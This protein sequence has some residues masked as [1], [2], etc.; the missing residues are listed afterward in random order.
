MTQAWRHMA[1]EEIKFNVRSALPRRHRWFSIIV[2]IALWRYGGI[3][4]F[5]SCGPEVGERCRHNMKRPV[6]MPVR[7]DGTPFST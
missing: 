7:S 5:D 3:E 4:A 2:Y 1:D 6:W